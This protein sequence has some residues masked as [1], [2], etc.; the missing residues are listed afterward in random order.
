[1][2]TQLLDIGEDCQDATCADDLDRMQVELE[3]ILRGVVIGL[4]DGTISSDGLETFK[5]GTSSCA[6]RSPCAARRCY[7]IRMRVRRPLHPS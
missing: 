6:T 2:A 7:V 3:S 5:L 4:R 1:M